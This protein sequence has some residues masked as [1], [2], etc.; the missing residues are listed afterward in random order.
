MLLYYITHRTQLAAD[1]SSRRAKLLARIAEAARCG[2]DYIQLREKDLSARELESLAREAVRA[3]RDTSSRT[4]L[5]I[6]SRSDVAL[7]VDADGVH[8][9][10]DDVSASDAR[11]LLARAGRPQALVAVSCHTLSEVVSAE[12]G[13]A[14]FAVFGPVFEKL[15][16]R[17]DAAQAAAGLAALRDICDRTAVTVKRMPVLA[18]GGVTVENAAQ[19]VKAGAAGVAGIRLF[20][21]NEIAQVVGTLRG[22]GK[23]QK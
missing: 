9:P 18:L 21:G 16:G 7:S 20:Q 10:A 8:L 12:A 15:G 2:V 4:R 5:L 14:N 22:E 3:V 1:E 23:S 19:C 17:A 11:A 13:G 6:N